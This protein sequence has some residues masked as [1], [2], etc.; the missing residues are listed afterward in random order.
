[1][2]NT[3]FATKIGMSQAWSTTGKR[4]PITKLLV[5]DNCVLNVKQDQ[6]QVFKAELAYG[7]KKLKNVAKPLRE[8][9]SKSGFSSGFKQIRSI[10]VDDRVDIGQRAE[11]RVE[12]ERIVAV[13]AINI[14]ISRTT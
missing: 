3:I 7:K 12:P 4:L 13:T 5:D 11:R 14:I 8:Q 10:E 1:M 6:N 9:I 2:L